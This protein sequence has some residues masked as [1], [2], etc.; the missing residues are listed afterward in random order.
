[1]LSWFEKDFTFQL[2]ED[3]RRFIAL[4]KIKRLV[5]PIIIQLILNFSLYFNLFSV[6]LFPPLPSRFR[7]IIHSVVNEHFGNQLKTISIGEGNSRQTVVFYRQMDK[8]SLTNREDSCE[9]NLSANLSK[10]LELNEEKKCKQRRPDMKFYVPPNAKNNNKIKSNSVSKTQ[11]NESR[12]EDSS[13]IKLDKYNDNGEEKSSQDKSVVL[14]QEEEPSWDEIYDDDGDCIKPQLLNVL[15]SS[16]KIDK[17]EEIE[18]EKSKIDYLKMNFCE[19]VIDE[20]S[21]FAHVLE[22]YD[23]PSQLKTQDL[24]T[25]ISIF[26]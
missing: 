12:N 25:S 22:V 5:F 9:N 6:L 23:F 20:D 13:E 11:I 4:N 17:E 15:K 16:L 24:V 19:P 8:L 3:I 18:I 10:S 21:K 26:K 2:V 7:F 1:M 14:K